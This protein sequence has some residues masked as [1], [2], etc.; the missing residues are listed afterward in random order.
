MPGREVSMCVA[1]VVGCP[2]S[3]GFRP[4][5]RKH[6][7]F[8]NVPPYKEWTVLIASVLGQANLLSV[9]QQ[10]DFSRKKWPH[11]YWKAYLFG[12]PRKNLCSSNFESECRTK[13]KITLNLSL[14][15]DDSQQGPKLW[16]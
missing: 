14:R 5:A 4:K 6:F 11:E 13:G 12:L 10:V 7:G 9:M 16:S 15:P 2:D 3:W 1:S 8:P